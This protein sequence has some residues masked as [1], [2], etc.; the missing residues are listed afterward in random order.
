MTARRKKI[1]PRESQKKEDTVARN[2]SKVANRS[3]FPMICG[4]GG[5]TRRLATAAGAEAAVQQRHEK[6]HTAV[7]RSTS[8]GQNVQNTPCSDHVCR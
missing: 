1:Q 5:S 7:A 3:V 6:L 2:V 4:S 8:S